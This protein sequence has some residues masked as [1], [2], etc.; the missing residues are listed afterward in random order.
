MGKSYIHAVEGGAHTSG[1]AV[2]RS[3]HP[4]FFQNCKDWLAAAHLFYFLD[5]AW[6]ETVGHFIAE[7]CAL[8]KKT[9]RSEY[10]L[11]SNL[12]EI[13]RLKL[14]IIITIPFLR[15]E[16]T[17]CIL[18][19]SIPNHLHGD[20]GLSPRLDVESWNNTG[21]IWTLRSKICTLLS[22]N[23]PVPGVRQ[24][25]VKTLWPLWKVGVLKCFHI[26]QQS[27]AILHPI[28]RVWLNW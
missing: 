3:I 12:V 23:C 15:I 6:V 26:Y 2:S 22:D 24:G 11:R 25:N 27:Q 5:N 1:Q 20:H 9:Y 18:S 16:V 28:S 13:K 19:C 4:V 14:I 7:T 10:F 17:N 8:K 21:F